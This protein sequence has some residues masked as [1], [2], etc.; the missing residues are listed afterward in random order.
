MACVCCIDNEFKVGSSSSK[1]TR[2]EGGKAERRVRAS[3]PLILQHTQNELRIR[4]FTKQVGALSPSAVPQA[5]TRLYILCMYVPSTCRT[6]LHQPRKD[7]CPGRTKQ[8][9]GRGETRWWSSVRRAF[10]YAYDGPRTATQKY[11]KCAHAKGSRGARREPTVGVAEAA[12]EE[13]I[14]WCRE[15]CVAPLRMTMNTEN[16]ILKHLA[17]ILQWRAGPNRRQ[18]RRPTYT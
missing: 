9:Q 12:K 3:K 14:P 13:S 6:Q 2:A 11:F 15:S 18:R 4:R 10:L 8:E 1:N 7:D 17:S 5:R 16:S